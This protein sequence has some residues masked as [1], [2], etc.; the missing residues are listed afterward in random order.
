MTA[1]L[2]YTDAR[3]TLADR[4]NHEALAVAHGRLAPPDLGRMQQVME[5]LG[6]PQAAYPV[7][8]LTGTNGKTS[9][10]RIAVTLLEEMGLGAGLYTSPDLGWVN[11]R[12]QRNGA[13]VSNEEF[14]AALASV[15][16]AERLV[17]GER[18]TWFELVTA[19]A[20]VWFADTA[21]DVAVIEVGMLGRWD[22][23]N[24][25]ESQVAVVTNVG[26][27]HAAYAGPT[28]AHVAREKAGI[29]KP[30]CTLV[31][32]ETDPEIA[33]LFDDRGQAATWRRDADWGL[34]ENRVAVGGR[35]LDLYTPGSRYRDVFVPL[36]GPHMGDNA[37]C[38]LAAAE[39]FFA[40]P[41]PEEV[42]GAALGRASS[43]G[44]LEV[45]G[46]R[47]LV[48]LDGAHNAE[49]M[50]A[51]LSSLREGFDVAGR[52][53]VVFGA[54]IG[55]DPAALLGLLDG[56][57][58]ASVVACAPDWPRAV[59]AGEVAAAATRLGLAVSTVP[60]VADAVAAALERAAPDDAVV[61]CGSLYVV[62][63]ARRA[64]T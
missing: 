21:V 40:A 8:H 57:E 38:A 39:A 29:V 30:G 59:P 12:M 54:L 28:R 6:R 58:V 35:L 1:A 16:A 3:A 49:G 26:L 10:A 7:I 47:P 33:A 60:R 55:H 27:D 25:V 52:T 2:T 18:L 20:L 64:L 11:E 48:V 51:L 36:H 32:G 23:T 14:A 56:A 62:G 46:H 53:H 50:Q 45:V 9:T 15:L 34:W 37:A 41:L 17:D 24:V 43:P 44:R 13:P 42:V 31:Q 63:E 4:V 19:T 22:A 61:V 5:A